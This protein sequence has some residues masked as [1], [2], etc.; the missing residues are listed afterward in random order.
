MPCRMANADGVRHL[1]IPTPPPNPHSHL[2]VGNLALA[3]WFIMTLIGSIRLYI[4]SPPPQR[5][6]A[7]TSPMPTHRDSLAAV[8]V[9]DCL[10]TVGGLNGEDEYAAETGAFEAYNLT[11]K[12]WSKPTD[13]DSPHKPGV[14][15]DLRTPRSSLS[16]VTVGSVLYAI[17]GRVIAYEQNQKVMNS[18]EAFNTTPGLL[19]KDA[20]TW[21][22]VCTRQAPVPNRT[23]SW[24]A[25]PCMPTARFSA[26]AEVVG[27]IIYVLGG[28]NGG[29]PTSDPTATSK[30]LP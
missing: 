5:A 15:P 7:S 23:L 14:L 11:S 25:L 9:D 1:F 18:F 16:V 27:T 6:W 17:G 19:G 3:M 30:P 26:T 28:Y 12:T 8:Y 24:L 13:P 22:A 21:T 10:Y 2:F 4:A 29:D 20:R